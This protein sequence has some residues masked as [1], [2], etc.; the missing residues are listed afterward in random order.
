LREGGY[1]TGAEMALEM[2]QAGER[3]T[4]IFTGKGLAVSGTLLLDFCSL[5]VLHGFFWDGGK[6]IWVGVSAGF[7]G[8]KRG[9]NLRSFRN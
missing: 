8:K 7:G 6:G 3:A 2:F 9:K 4:A 5:L 1:S